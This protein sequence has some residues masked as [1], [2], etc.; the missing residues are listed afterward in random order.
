MNFW[1]EGAEGLKVTIYDMDGKQLWQ[2]DD[3]SLIEQFHDD[4]E[5]A[6]KGGV[7]RVRIEAPTHLATI[8]DYNIRI[9]G[10]PPYIGLAP[11]LL[12]KPIPRH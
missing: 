4:G 6:Q 10:I 9:V 7:F 2:K 1:G 3:I 5:L 8:E 11:N 12:M